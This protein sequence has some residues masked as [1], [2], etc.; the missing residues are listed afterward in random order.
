MTDSTVFEA[1]FTTVDQLDAQ[2]LMA[3]LRTA[4]ATVVIIPVHNG[5]AAVAGCLDAVLERTRGPGVELLVIDDASTDPAIVELLDEHQARGSITL[6]RFD[7]N[8]GFTRTVNEGMRWADGRDVILLNSDTEVGPGWWRRLRWVAYSHD[9]AGTASA[10]S[11]HA[12]TMSIPVPHQHNSWHPRRPWADVAELV[13]AHMPVWSQE[14][15]AAHGFCMYIRREALDRV[16]EFDADA[17]PIGYGEEV[18]FSQRLLAA[19]WVN[20]VAPH[21]MVRHLRAQSFGADARRALVENSR[22]VLRQ[23]YPRLADQVTDWETSVG[24]RYLRRVARRLQRAGGEMFADAAQISA[25]FEAK[26]ESR[27][28]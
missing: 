26:I 17:F 23:R 21:V 20:L 28:A 11:D 22:A 24:D 15:P 13:A 12:G 8:R 27:P 1:P 4:P 19:G 16:G 25:G 18:D 7:E 10:V 3:R 14:V 2:A 9:R 5:G 6:L